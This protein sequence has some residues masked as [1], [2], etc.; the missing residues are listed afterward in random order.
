MR[1]SRGHE[2]LLSDEQLR[3][4][5]PCELVQNALPKKI[6]GAETA[7]T[8]SENHSDWRAVLRRSRGHKQPMSDEELRQA[9]PCELVRNALPKD[10]A[11]ELPHRAT[12]DPLRS[13]FR[14]S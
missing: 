14:R 3:Q 13:A 7:A 4:A 9:T 1:R 5:T 11:E 12:R 10:L 6:A 8:Q 2:Q